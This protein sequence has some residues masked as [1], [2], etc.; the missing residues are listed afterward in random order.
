MLEVKQGDFYDL[1]AI[2]QQIPEFLT[3]KNIENL[4]QRLAGKE[5]LLLVTYDSGRPVGY[6]LGYALNKETFYSW[7]GA[8]IPS[9]RK[10]GLAQ[11]MLI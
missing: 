7:L 2:E 9:H 6:K 10:L 11:K 1:I 5:H 4:R 3:P 8:V